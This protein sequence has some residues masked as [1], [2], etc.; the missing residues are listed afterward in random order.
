MQYLKIEEVDAPA[1]APTETSN[2]PVAVPYA[3]LD[4][5]YPGPHTGAEY[6]ALAMQTASNG[7]SKVW[8]MY[9]AGLNPTSA[10]S[11]FVV[12]NLQGTDTMQVTVETVSNRSYHIEFLDGPLTNAQ[13]WNPFA[14]NGSWT[15]LAPF[16]NQH[17]FIDT[18]AA[19]NSGVPL[20]AQRNY[21][22][23]VNLP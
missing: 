2:S 1:P 18:G 4:A 7:V 16:A 8:E 11:L 14:A 15:N 22:I 13:V 20:P 19:T 23:R 10:T 5:Y 12:E 9:V 17:I 6:E 3:W 21:R